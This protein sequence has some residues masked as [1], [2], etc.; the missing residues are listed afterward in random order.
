MLNKEEL[1]KNISDSDEKTAYARALDKAAA[2]QRKNIPAYTAFFD[3]F[4]LKRLM[5]MVGF[6]GMQAVT[7]GG[8]EGAERRMIG[9]LPD[10]MEF[11]AED[12]PITPVEICFTRFSK[13]LTHRDFLGS[14]L[15]IGITRDKVGDIIVEDERAV[16]YAD[17]SIADYIAANLEYVGHTKVRTGLLESYS[18]PVS[19]PNE[20]KMTVAS[21]RLDAVLGGCFNLSRTRVAELIKGE[22]AYI[23][24]L[25]ESSPS[26]QVA[27]GDI[28]TLRGSG[29]AVIKEINGKTKK[30]RILITVEIYK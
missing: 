23:N 22:K 19:A 4:K 5:D 28:I 18:P 2:A 7:Y 21:L 14:V 29:R 9:F 17:S 15:G 8:Y 27:E 13:G 6:C 11:A 3:P 26:K 20:K 24:W 10:Y 30:D 16:V 1:L 25:G 12:F